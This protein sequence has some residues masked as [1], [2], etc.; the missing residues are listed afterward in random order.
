MVVNGCS[1]LLVVLFFHG[2]SNEM[3][4]FKAIRLLLIA[5]AVSYLFSLIINN[6]ARVLR[7]EIGVSITSMENKDFNL[8]PL[9]TFCP[10]W[11][12]NFPFLITKAEYFIDSQNLD[13]KEGGEGFWSTKFKLIR[14]GRFVPC[15]TYE[16]PNPVQLGTYLAVAEFI[17]TMEDIDDLTLAIHDNHGYINTHYSHR[18]NNR[19]TF[20]TQ[21]LGGNVERESRYEIATVLVD[22]LSSDECLTNPEMKDNYCLEKNV[23]ETLNCS[24]P[25]IDFEGK[26]DECKQYISCLYSQDLS[27]FHF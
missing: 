22:R 15:Y 11:K 16:R 4:I 3:N 25:G 12:M 24:I 17:I 5:F 19:L 8:H 13:N 26:N 14:A 27:Y 9:Y 1:F 20:P 21:T 2:F 23:A 10:Q 7:Y 18:G 6:V